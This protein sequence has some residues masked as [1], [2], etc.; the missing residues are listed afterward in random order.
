MAPVDWGG[1]GRGTWCR[2]SPTR[3]ADDRGRHHRRHRDAA[4]DLPAFR[5]DPGPR[6]A[7]TSTRA[8]LLVRFS[9]REVVVALARGGLVNMA[10]VIMAAAAF[11]AGPQRRR[12]HRD[13]LS[14]ADAAA[15]R[16]RPRPCSSCRSSR[17]A[18][19]SSVVGTMAGQMI[20]Q[21]FVGIAIPVWV[22]R[23]VTM[24]PAFAVVAARRRRHQG[25]GAEPGGAEPRPPRADARAAVVHDPQAAHGR[26]RELTGDDD[27]RGGRRRQW[28]CCCTRSCCCRPRGSKSPASLCRR[29][30]APTRHLSHRGRQRALRL[31]SRRRSRSSDCSRRRSPEAGS[32]Q[33]RLTCRGFSWP[34][35]SLTASRRRRSAIRERSSIILLGSRSRMASVR[36]LGAPA[37]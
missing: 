35:A 26:L 32:T 4:R 37:R 24:V 15:R 31:T 6:A 28:C 16:R 12:R 25:A 19:S 27:C 33:L 23:L 36:R 13:R 2:A 34:S 8:R 18:I 7:P 5:P 14:H 3:G 17:R 20:M 22:R 1:R 11:H 10:M 21:G 29:F 30:K 9:N